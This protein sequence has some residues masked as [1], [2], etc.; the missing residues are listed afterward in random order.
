MID[1]ELAAR[2]EPLRAA[3]GEDATWLVGGAVRDLLLGRPLL[4]WDVLVPEDAAAA[5]RAYARRV[6]AHVFPLSERHGAWRVVEDARTVD[7]AA[8]GPDLDANLRERDLTVNAIALRLAD[9]TLVDP[10][11]GIADLRAGRLVACTDGAMRADPLR[12]MRVARLAV[13]L[14]LAIDPATEAICRRDAAL[15]PAAAPERILAELK[16]LLAGPDAV[17]ALL[18]LERL[19]VLAA[20]LPEVAALRGVEQSRFHHLDVLEHTLHVI[21]ATADVA[22]H[23]AHY[24]PDADV[25]AAI[26]RDLAAPVEAE[27]DVRAALRFGALLHDIAKPA[28]RTVLDGGRIGFPGHARDGVAVAD[29][30]LARL[31]AGHGLRRVTRVLVREHLRLGFLARDEPLD[32]RTAYRYAAETEPYVH[33]SIVVSLGDRLATRGP[34]TRQRG[35]RRHA[36]VARAMAAAYEQQRLR[37][38]VPVV[39]GDVLADAVGLAPGPLVGEAVEAVR[40]EQAAGAVADADA[41]I[42]FAR[43]W[44]AERSSGSTRG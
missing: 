37:L 15:A 5:A 16:R 3:L 12:L 17:D 31:A 18:L 43:R 30:I 32:P 11:D 33:A 24:F 34:G 25:A 41:A 6:G 8:A 44:L 2:L 23:V 10:L 42:A 4:D 26:E 35:L 39:R 9:R 19:G 13:E 14:D 22:D 38:A 7:F 28:T 1:A 20:V 40:E 27:L 21:E 36:A 29:G